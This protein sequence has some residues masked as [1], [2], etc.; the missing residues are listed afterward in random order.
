MLNNWHRLVILA[1]ASPLTISADFANAVC[2][3]LGID[4]WEIANSRVFYQ[5]QQ[6]WKPFSNFSEM[7]V[8][9]RQSVTFAY[10]VREIFRGDRSGAIVVKSG[11]YNGD[12]PEGPQGDRVLLVRKE[13]VTD[14]ECP[15]P[16][17]FKDTL[18]SG[19]GYEDYHEYQLTETD[20]LKK[21]LPIFERFHIKYWRDR[22]CIGT[23][24]SRTRPFAFDH[25]ASQFSYNTDVVDGGAR[26]GIRFNVFGR[27]AYAAPEGLWRRRTEIKY[28]HTV[29]GMRC[30]KFNLVVSKDD[31]N[32]LRINDLE[33]RDDPPSK[34]RLKEYRSSN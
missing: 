9:G 2:D 29:A 14:R 28:Y 26:V 34:S 24:D 12:R 11:V 33:G 18:V 4:D 27:P 31:R 30:L 16:S 7:P 32:F 25:N 6:G 10:V 22:E 8:A 17:S 13:A 21:E 20:E 1:L 19:K 5:T 23:N 3:F 15:Q